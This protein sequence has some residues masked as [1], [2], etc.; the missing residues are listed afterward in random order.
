[1]YETDL[2]IMLRMERV[3]GK[4][5]ST[6]LAENGPFPEDYTRHIIGQVLLAAQYLHKKN[7]AHLDFKP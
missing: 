5:I 4:D 2:S 3:D 6:L 1:M 7:I